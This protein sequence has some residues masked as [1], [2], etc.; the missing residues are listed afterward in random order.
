M[1]TNEGPKLIEYN[2]RFGDPECQVIMSRIKS[3]L[4][5]GIIAAT[6]HT[7]DNFNLKIL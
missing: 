7:L 5:E 6:D 4:F 2:V 3:N 1:L